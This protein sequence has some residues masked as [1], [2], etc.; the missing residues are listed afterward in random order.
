MKVTINLF[1]LIMWAATL[2]TSHQLKAQGYR[3]DGKGVIRD[4]ETGD[5]VS[6][7]GVNYTLP[8]AHAYRMHKALGV[9]LRE[10]IDKDV[11]HFARLGF[12]AYRIH[13][14]DI[15][16]SDLKGNLLEN[17]HLNLFDYLV[18]KLKER[19][20]R[21]LITPM[22]YWGNGYPER[23]EP[24]P[25]FSSKWNKRE[26]NRNDTAIAAQENYLRQFASHINPYTGIS[27][28]DEPYLVGFEINNE[29]TNDTDPAFTT[30]YVNRM[31][32]AIRS[33]GCKAP[34]FYNMSHNFQNTQAFYNADIDGGTFQWYPSGLVAGRTRMGNFLPAVDKYPIPFD[35]IKN[36]NRKALVVYEF[37]AADVADSYLYPA[38]ARS[39][40]GA[41]F[42]WVTQ[43]AY[44]PL[45]MAW[46]NT[47][48][49]THFLNL[50]YTPQK[51]IGMKI[52]GEVMKLV[53]RKADFGT[54]PA[55]T[56]FSSFRVSYNANLAEMNTPAKFMHTNST[57][58]SPVNINSL[59]E[60]TGYGSSPVISYEGTGAYFLDK[61]TDGIWRLE[62]MPDA[63]WLDDP[64]AR[65][66]LKRVAADVA[67][68]EWPIGINI[69][70]LGESFV[71][72]AINSGNL[73]KGVA[74][75]ASF[76]VYPG[77][78]L[79][80]R[81]GSD[82]G[83]FSGNSQFG[84]IKL[85]EFV[86]PVGRVDEFRVAHR[87]AEAVTAGR[88]LSLV[89]QV[90][91]PVI[92]DS[93]T[94][95]PLSGGWRTRPVALKRVSGYMW[96]GILPAEILRD[97]RF[98]YAI[99]VFS[100]GKA[101]SFPSKTVGSPSDWDFHAPYN[102]SSL[103]II[104]VEAAGRF[105]NLFDAGDFDLAEAYLLKGFGVQ[106]TEVAGASP[107]DGRIRFA[108]G[109][110]DAGNG[111][112]FRAWIKEKTDGRREKLSTCKTLKIR[113]GNI[114]GIGKT[115]AGFI[116]SEGYAFRGA[117]NVE[118]NSVLSLPLDNLVLRP[119]LIRPVA[120]P[121]F[122][123]DAFTPVHPAKFNSSNIEMLEI[124]VAGASGEAKAAAVEICEAWL[125]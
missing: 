119:A 3:V 115:E 70:D 10:A 124:T 5:E 29:P 35:S 30:A 94:V 48:Y 56:I 104:N 17:E 116:T 47:E 58:T 81:S 114:E 93:V 59:T 55:D 54:Y 21:L 87:P 15:E 22:A 100:G 109:K 25:G 120:Y 122:L 42:Q 34:V 51:A 26:V 57:S 82:G 107:S 65:P 24:M 43:F 105:I 79:L 85:G 23:D 80:K 6:F 41:G 33:T 77:V 62:L 90:T 18:F 1:I 11:Y 121:S 76:M 123:P 50:A 71:Y 4:A 45:E 53:P 103:Y 66:S 27:Y 111:I 96:K 84:S 31:V 38:I 101:L 72:E 95:F 16:I 78:Y 8:F 44:D 108:A 63:V 28:A 118:A 61:I 99:T 113:F 7:Y 64:F 73:R 83:N 102:S 49:Q 68:N 91:G 69:P 86:A 98:A 97:G 110:L 88:D 117:I 13:V 92:P 46:A 32:K 52:A 40:R 89:A 36:F 75:A 20:L 14:W 19:R 74:T 112:I 37:D 125:D 12:N 67:W 60:I 9:D 106:K 39:F 2:V